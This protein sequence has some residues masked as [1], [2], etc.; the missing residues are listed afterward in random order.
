M[1]F[2]SCISLYQGK[3]VKSTN[4]LLIPF[5]RISFLSIII[6]SKFIL[7]SRTLARYF[8][9]LLKFSCVTWV[10]HCWTLENEHFITKIFTAMLFGDSNKKVAVCPISY[11]ILWIWNENWLLI[12]FIVLI[13]LSAWLPLLWLNCSY[14]TP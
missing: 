9:F 8:S 5:P 10:N 14:F 4:F 1:S 7:N 13:F 3:K 11:S 12:N 6:S 2:F